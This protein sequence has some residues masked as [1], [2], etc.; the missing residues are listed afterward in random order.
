MKIK[1]FTR[2]FDYAV[3]NFDK[4]EDYH[5]HSLPGAT[6]YDKKTNNNYRNGVSIGRK[7]M[8]YRYEILLLT[9]MTFSL[10]LWS[11]GW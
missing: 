2:G 4:I 9:F 6:W 10:L 3:K 5:F 8:Q 7:Y 1:A 11:F